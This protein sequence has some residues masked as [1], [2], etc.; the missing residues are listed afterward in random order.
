[1]S[2]KIIKHASWSKF[3]YFIFQMAKHIFFNYRGNIFFLL[4]EAT[5][6]KCNESDILI[7][8]EENWNKG[9]KNLHGYGKEEK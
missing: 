1:M 5:C 4:K 2:E 6:D 7:T 3:G 8:Q 9:R